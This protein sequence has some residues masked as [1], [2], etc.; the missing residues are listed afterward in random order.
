M[1]PSAP[2]P[3][4]PQPGPSPSIRRSATSVHKRIFEELGTLSELDL[5]KSYAKRV[6]Y[7]CAELCKRVANIYLELFGIKWR[8]ELYMHEATRSQEHL[9]PRGANLGKQ[10]L[11]FQSLIESKKSS[12]FQQFNHELDTMVFGNTSTDL[13]I[14]TLKN[15][16]QGDSL[17][18]A[19][20]VY[21]ESGGH[22]MVMRFTR[23][24]DESFNL[25]FANTGLGLSTNQDFHPIHPEKSHLVQTVAL[26]ENIPKDKI[27]ESHFLETYF[28]IASS[29]K[30]PNDSC[31]SD[32]DKSK[33]TEKFEKEKDQMVYANRVDAAYDC[34]RT[35]GTPV[36]ADPNSK[37]YSRAQIGGSC[38]A[39]SIWSMG[40]MILSE[41][42]LKE[43]ETD[44]K[45]K[46]L[47]RNY[48][49]IKNGYD[50]SSTRKI[51][52]LDQVQTLMKIYD[53]P[54]LKKIENELL[55]SLNMKR[56]ELKI[57][58][59][60]RMKILNYLKQKGGDMELTPMIA[61]FSIQENSLKI[62]PKWAEDP[63][64]LIPYRVRKNENKPDFYVGRGHSDKCYLLYLA[65]AN[66]EQEQSEDYL[67]QVMGS[68]PMRTLNNKLRQTD[69]ILKLLLEGLKKVNTRSDIAK[70]YFLALLIKLHDK[71]AISSTYL[72]ALER[73]YLGLEVGLLKDNIW[74]K[75]INQL[76][77]ETITP[78]QNDPPSG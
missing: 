54:V 59:K 77:A 74:V 26:L 19:A 4:S 41:S 72:K 27:F 56:T 49:V 57:A 42:E 11:A 13:R 28:S 67:N 36:V 1:E 25:E 8:F 61:T 15:L 39:S 24:Q 29:G 51:L 64:L 48:E 55:S 53:H 20:N 23:N 73:K 70:R 17:L 71:H 16:K 62:L 44:S 5:Q 76:K 14:Q 37:A 10:A 69:K 6:M 33:W 2:T 35:L 65:I 66:G 60:F 21:S 12:G 32:A 9:I 22:A 34:M 47:L 40:R 18:M 75:A 30:I 58:R 3:V 50:Q 63:S 46:S 7:A 78:S 31:L 68:L 52:V 43:A 38:T 45:I